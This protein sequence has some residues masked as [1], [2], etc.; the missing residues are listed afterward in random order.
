M[1]TGISWTDETWNPIVGCSKISPGCQNCY[2]AESAKSVRLQQFPQYQAV[3]EWNGVIAFVES[4]LPKPL[5]WKKP[6]K[7]FV[8]SMSDLFHENVTDEMR[9]RVFAVMRLCPQHTFQVST[10]RPENA[11]KYLTEKTR[12]R[13]ANLLNSYSPLNPYTLL[14]HK[15]QYRFA[16]S[17]HLVTFPLPNVWVGVTVENQEMANQRIPTLLEIPAAKRWL[18]MEPLLGKVDLEN[19]IFP[20]GDIAGVLSESNCHLWYDNLIN[21]VVIGGE[22]GKNARPCNVN[23]IQAIADQCKQSGVAVWVKQLGKNSIG[24]TGYRVH[25]K[26]DLVGSKFENLPKS[27]QIREFPNA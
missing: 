22:S 21:W 15:E 16:T 12:I 8:C 24:D 19:I 17:R 11:I 14:G 9:D 13:I 6:K 23:L 1:P 10:K 18:S 3:K 25:P 27:L 2:A 5:R 20:D 4:A 7:I 26:G